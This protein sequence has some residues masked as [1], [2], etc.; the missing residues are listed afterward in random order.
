[1]FRIIKKLHSVHETLHSKLNA[2][3]KFLKFL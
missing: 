1:M 3:I 2:D